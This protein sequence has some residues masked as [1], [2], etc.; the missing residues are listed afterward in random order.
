MRYPDEWESDV[1]LADGGTVHLRPIRA[2]DDDALLGLYERLSDES[3]YLRFFS[4]VSRPTASQLDRL[5]NV[6]Y[7]DRF[8][9]AAQLGDDIVAV[10]R[11]DRT[12][13]DDAEVAF[14]VQ[15]DQQGRGLGTIM[16]E[17]LAVVARTH[18]IRRFYAET[19][20]DNRK[21]LG[22]FRDAGY[23]VEREFADGV[24][25]VAFS[26]E[27]TDASVSVQEAREQVSEARSTGRLLAPH[28]IAVIGAGRHPGTIGHEV[29]RNLVAGEFTGPVYPVNPNAVAVASVR[30]YPTVLDVP[31]T[32]DLAVIIVPAAAVA[33]AVEQCAQ[34]GVHG[35]V[36]ISA[37]FAEVG[38]AETERALV[39]VAR[40]NGMRLVGP[41]CMGIVN[42]DP[43]VSMNATFA[44]FPPLRGRVA[45]ASQSGAL[46]IELL[47]QAAELGLGVSTFVSMGNKADVSSND[48]LQY[49]EHDASTD[50]ILLYLESFGNPRKFARLARRVSRSKPI[51]AVKSG[52]GHAGSRAARSHTAALASSDVATDALFHQAGVIRVDTIAELFDT[53]RL[54][55][56]QPLPG[57]R[58]VAIVSNGGGPGILAS[59]ACE[60]VGLVVPELSSAT[61]S[62]LRSFVSPDASTANP[63]D[64]VASATAATYE[65]ALRTVLADPDVDAVLTIFVPPLVTNADD[66]ARA[67]VGAAHDAGD[68][69]VLACFLTRT[70]APD[71]LRAGEDGRR[72]IPNYPLP[73][74]AAVA[75]GRAADHADWRRRPSGTIPRLDGIDLDAA[76]AVVTA[77]LTDRA[78]AWL[79]AEDAVALCRAFGIPVAPVQRATSAAEAAAAADAVGYPVAL[80]AGAPE[81]VHKTDAG[82][83]RLGL[84]GPDAVR[85]A[86]TDMEAALGAALGG[87]VVQPMVAGGIETIVGV[88][89]D[90]SFGPLVL[91]GMGGVTAE[92]L[93]D[94]ALR[95]VPLT[96]VDAAELVR[97]PRSSPLLFGYRGS[98]PTDTD[99]LEDL[100]LRVGRLA[101]ALPEVR[102]LDCNPV[103]V[104][105]TGVTAV[106]VKVRLARVPATPSTALRRLRPA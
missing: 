15:D 57:G 67:I 47:G 29:F 94:T 7:Q 60:G 99:A 83:V 11:Y 27:P 46:G 63:V 93:R 95:L 40:R 6:D 101:D 50:V 41:N 98:D 58:R 21:M 30:A 68:K 82:G 34:K 9:L 104:G 44:P 66:V 39:E 42:T 16:L 33:A 24:V 55:A 97:A 25:N 76:R 18:G 19:L 53:A 49:W 71:L 8:A 74:S 81:L 52:R 48:L 73:E 87:V 100:L 20:P 38:G 12:R 28:S 1:V 86:F 80:K 91:F 62:A 51:I 85:A 89:Q 70:A 23:V 78:D 79:A 32:V 2:D 54:L 88:T 90:P 13:G 5:T 103:L 4:P 77:A 36:V 3:I 64:L 96:D 65:R 43:F 45:F 56:T 69:P 14:T 106:D 84:T 92:L 35:L 22:V 59:D 105:P 26:I 61:Q 17:H 72:T 75:L 37:G 10:A 102:E 31:D